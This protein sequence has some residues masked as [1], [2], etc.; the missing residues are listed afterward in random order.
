[1][2]KI[3][4]ILGNLEGVVAARVNLSTRRVTVTWRQAQ[5][6]SA[7]PLLATL[8]E[9]GF[10]ANLQPT[11]RTRRS[12]KA[13]ADRRDSGRRLRGDEHHAAFGVGLVR[14]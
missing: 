1:M 13:P 6:A 10:E 7:P 9:A 3:E 14:R 12:R 2:A 5:T 8:N 11:G 4:R